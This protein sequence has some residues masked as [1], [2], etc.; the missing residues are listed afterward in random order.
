MKYSAHVH[1][2]IENISDSINGLLKKIY[3]MQ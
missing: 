3:E 2:Y 1:L